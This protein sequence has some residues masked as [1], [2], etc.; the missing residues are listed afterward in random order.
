VTTQFGTPPADTPDAELLSR[1]FQLGAPIG[2]LARVE[3][4]R[5]NRV[6]KL[7]TTEGSFA[8]KQLN[9]T[10]AARHPRVLDR[11]RA[12]EQIAAT[13]AMAGIPAVVARDAETDPLREVDG[14]WFL[15]Y[16]WI[17][18]ST[19]DLATVTVE[20]ARTAG[21]LIGRLHSR[22]LRHAGVPAVDWR[23]VSTEQWRALAGR[24]RGQPWA[25]P[26]EGMLPPLIAMS[27][28]YRAAAKALRDRP[29]LVSHRDVDHTNV[30]WRDGAAW[31]IDW[32]GT[33]WTNPMVELAGAAI[34]WSGFSDGRSDEAIF[35]AV[36]DG[37]QEA[38][39][40]SVEDAIAALAAAIGGSL[41]WQEFSVRRALGE[42]FT[43]EDREVGIAQTVSN[44]NALS[45]VAQHG[46]KWRE[47]LL[48][49]G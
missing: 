10:V 33:A 15:A 36:L 34:A 38:A 46:P 48:A 20:Q 18:G 5:L 14:S 39:R 47:W 43:E 23:S 30:L 7:R 12:T 22:D 37:Y 45:K 29:V 17:D 44:L 26:L 41:D 31:L 2:N 21:E 16:P 25:T 13:F 6:W 42:A 32:E 9:P 28:D 40:L 3:G 4:G 1:A 11:F 24:S 19:A 8:I 49:P 35:R 27:D